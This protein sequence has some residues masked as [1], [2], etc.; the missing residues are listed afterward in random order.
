[1]I[2]ILN[3]LPTGENRRTQVFTPFRVKTGARPALWTSPLTRL[4]HEHMR[5]QDSKSEMMPTR[6]PA[7]AARS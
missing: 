1:Q 3:V 5:T 7:R 4:R 6:P 2:A